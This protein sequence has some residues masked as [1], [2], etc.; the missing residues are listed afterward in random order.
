MRW[1]ARGRVAGLVYTLT[2]HAAMTSTRREFLKDTGR[3][4]AT[5]ALATAGL[6]NVYAAGNETI[7]VA[8]VGCGGR[9]SGAASNVLKSSGGPTELV[10]MADVFV[11]RIQQSHDAL[12]E[13]HPDVMR[14]PEERQFLGFDAYRHAMDSLRP[15]DLVILATPPAFRWVHFAYAIEKGLHVFM[16]KPVTVDGPTSRRMLELSERA[17][18]R[19]LKV[20]V[21]LMVRHC[22]GR[23]ELHDRIRSG[24]IG[25]IVALRAYRMQGQAGSVW[26][27]PPPQGMSELLYQVQR[28]HSFLWASGGMYSDFYIHQIDECCW[29]KGDWPVEAQGS[30][31]RHYRGTA[32]DQNFDNYSVEYTYPDGSKL[33]LYGRTMENT[34][35]QFSSYAHGTRGSA[36]ISFND[37]TPGKVRIFDGQ[38]VVNGRPVWAFPQPEPNP[39]QTEID[40]L[41][42]A[43][44][45]DQPFNEVPRG[46]QASLVTSMGR[47]AAHTGRVVTYDEILNG[48]HEFAPGLDQLTMDSPAPLQADAG[49]RYPVPRPGIMVEREY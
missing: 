11:R 48:D 33:F 40:D 24:A 29:M 30:G 25:D 20:G 7:R 39:Y 41:L 18:E 46:V 26:S 15:G 9:G 4:A 37:H 8:L 13:M 44:R 6:Q 2:E 10:A 42:H 16:E 27:D 43:I 31:G 23:E 47:M 17:D 5:S 21:G 28:F 12:S 36:V 45:N 49:G 34:H 3:L 22:R 14:V 19:N 1:S 38:D 32:V 35:N